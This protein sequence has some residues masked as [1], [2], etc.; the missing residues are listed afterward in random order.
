MTRSRSRSDRSVNAHAGRE[1]IS[2]QDKYALVDPAKSEK[3]L[4]EVLRK[5]A[6]LRE[7]KTN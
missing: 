2:D 5:V 7:N 4:V 1:L 3:A 6:T